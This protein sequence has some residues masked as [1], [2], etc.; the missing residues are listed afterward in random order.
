[1][2]SDDDATFGPAMRALNSYQRKFVL[3]MAAD[4]FGNA[5]KW[6]IAAGYSDVK[7]GAK[8][9][10]YMCIHN[11]KVE[12]AVAEFA[13]T[14]LNVL[15]PILATSGMM[16]IARNPKHR[17]HLKACE[18][19]ANR[20]GFGEEQT[21]NVVRT[22]QT[23]AAM[24]ERIKQLAAALGID[25]AAL[26]G[27]NAAPGMKVIEHERGEDGDHRRRA[28]EGVAG[29]SGAER[30]GVARGWGERG[31][32]AGADQAVAGRG[33][34]DVPAVAGPDGDDGADGAQG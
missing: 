12:A 14:Q 10:G 23:G 15:G 30:G 17:G 6:A 16:R 13:R 7:G 20:V 8:V 11:P 26:L 1:M 22:D 3:A 24:V 5:R 32:P 2:V 34:Q 21:I 9:Q 27:A 19:L 33:V 4:P 31:E 25:P 29:G 28:G 18:L